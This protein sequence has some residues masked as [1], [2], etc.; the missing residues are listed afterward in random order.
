MEQLCIARF[1]IKNTLYNYN[2]TNDNVR[3]FSAGQDLS[4]DWV[5]AASVNQ[6]GTGKCVKIN[7]CGPGISNIHPAHNERCQ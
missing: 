1:N 3:S 6:A 2:P 4:R 5:A 7:G